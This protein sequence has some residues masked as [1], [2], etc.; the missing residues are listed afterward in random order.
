MLASGNVPGLLRP[1]SS[2]FSAT[3][4]KTN[5]KSDKG[6]DKIAAATA[7]TGPPAI[8]AAA[9]RSTAGIIVPSRKYPMT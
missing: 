6:T 4:P 5:T 9:T 2:H 1:I 7:R 8:Q 3:T